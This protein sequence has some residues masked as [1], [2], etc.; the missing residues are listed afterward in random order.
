MF[1][2]NTKHKKTGRKANKLGRNLKKCARYRSENR[3][4]KN[5]DRRARRILKG[6]RGGEWTAGDGSQ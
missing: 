3:R 2:K 5:R 4:D 1:T 6:H